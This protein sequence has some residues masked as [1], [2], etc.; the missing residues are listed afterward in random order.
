MTS[1]PRRRPDR[2][3]ISS[4]RPALEPL[5]Y[6]EVPAAYHFANGVFTIRMAEIAN[7]A[8]SLDTRSDGVVVINSRAS[9]GPNNYVVGAP[10][11]RLHAGVVRRL[12]VHGSNQDD[13]IA[14]SRVD[15]RAFNNLSG[16]VDIYG[17]GGRDTIDGTAFDDRIRGGEGNDRVF[18]LA[19][20]DRIWGDGGHDDLYGDGN[21]SKWDRLGGH[22]R[23][24]GG[25]GNDRLS[26]Y[27][28][29]DVLVGRAG[30]DYFLG[31]VGADTAWIDGE[32]RRPRYGWPG[33]EKVETGIPPLV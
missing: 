18:G 23:I 7:R 25:S 22:D 30:D 11:G 4:A 28:G 33:V 17:N 27:G 26:G 12:V 16:R 5:E 24:D 10:N 2:L 1:L 9:G 32:D 15:T 31:G 14:L 19:G 29:N 3:P 8:V 6:R 21:S 13:N 20:D